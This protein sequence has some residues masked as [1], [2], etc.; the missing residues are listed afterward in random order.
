MNQLITYK[1]LQSIPWPRLMALGIGCWYGRRGKYPAYCQPLLNRWQSFW[2]HA[3]H[4][5][6]FES[7]V[8]AAVSLFILADSSRPTTILAVF[9][10]FNISLCELIHTLDMHPLSGRSTQ[11]S[12][13]IW[14]D[15]FG[16]GI[17][18]IFLSKL[19][20]S[21]RARTVFTEQNWAVS[22]NCCQKAISFTQHQCALE[23]RTQS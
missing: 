6:Q 4:L 5:R 16:K 23:Y 17:F 8:W 11:T 1:I 22:Q 21:R 19:I 14:R 15:D 20:L 12:F 18:Q 3:Q 13:P 9:A 10:S 2:D 7:S